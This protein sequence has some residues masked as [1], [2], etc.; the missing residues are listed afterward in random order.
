MKSP[1]ERNSKTPVGYT[2][3]AVTY[4]TK[5]GVEVTVIPPVNIPR[6]YRVAVY[7]RVS[8]SHPE[9]RESLEAQMSYY[10]DYVHRHKAW[11]FVGAY[12]DVKSARSIHSREQFE[13]MISDCMEGRIDIIITKTVSRFGRNTAETLSTLRMLKNKGVDVFFENEG[14]HS[15]DGNDEFLISL[16]E[17]I[18]Q[19]ESESRSQNIKWG[20]K[21]QAQR[22]DAAIYSRPCY[23][24]RKSPDGQLVMIEEEAKTVRYIYSLYRSGY[25]VLGIKKELEANGILTPTGKSTW[26]KRTIETILANEKYTGDVLIYKTYC[27]EYPKTTRIRNRGEKDQYL[28]SN[29][30]PAIIERAVFDS[31]QDEK[32]RRSNIELD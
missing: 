7:C 31:V 5:D 19:A 6:M 10:K 18:A 24:Y 3:N 16:M 30:H 29:H 26:P 28:I 4:I 13:K 20:I 14:L 32:K 15:I 17:A 9:Q 22:P 27:S 21:Q 1:F 12:V 8:T 23:G 25:S 2:G 11:L